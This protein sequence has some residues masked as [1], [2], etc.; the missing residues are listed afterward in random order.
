LLDEIDPGNDRRA[1]RVPGDASYRISANLEGEADPANDAGLAAGP[2]PRHRANRAAQGL[3]PPSRVQTD[4]PYR[5]S[6]DHL[7]RARS[8][9]LATGYLSRPIRD[10]QRLY[11]DRAYRRAAVSLCL[12]QVQVNCRARLG[13]NFPL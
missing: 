8:S 2:R 12:D 11:Y 3:M 6:R 5:I 10:A 4:P 9:D 7:L 1:G 13:H